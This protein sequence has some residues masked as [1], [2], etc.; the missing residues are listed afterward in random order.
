MM[1]VGDGMGAEQTCDYRSE[2]FANAAGEYYSEGGEIQGRW[3]GKLADHYGLDGI[4]DAEAY[5]RLAHG[6]HPVTNELLVA[7]VKVTPYVNKFGKTIAPAA[8]TASRDIVFSPP[9][10]F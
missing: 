3:F 2:H 1:T 8:H 10:E 7:P 5:E 4:V 6:R 9:K